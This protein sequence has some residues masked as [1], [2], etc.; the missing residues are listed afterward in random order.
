VGGDSKGDV[1]LGS[2]VPSFS[3]VGWSYRLL[4]EK[5]ECGSSDGGVTHGLQEPHG[6]VEAWVQMIDVGPWTSQKCASEIC[7]CCVSQIL[8]EKGAA[9]VWS[10][11]RHDAPGGRLGA[12]VP[13]VKSILL[14]TYLY[15][16]M[17]LRV[18]EGVSISGGSAD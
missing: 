9:R 16:L 7:A 12:R 15:G 5:A 2:R 14:L 8:A 4:Q 18:C 17:M 13:T 11:D 6:E 3:G 1:S 10:R